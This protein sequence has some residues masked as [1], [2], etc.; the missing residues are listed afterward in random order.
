[1]LPQVAACRFFSFALSLFTYK[2]LYWSDRQ[3]SFGSV[4]ALVLLSASVTALVASDIGSL[5]ESF[6]SGTA[7]AAVFVRDAVR[8]IAFQHDEL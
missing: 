6:S 1:M 3:I 7:D 5:I 4:F 8:S 2:L